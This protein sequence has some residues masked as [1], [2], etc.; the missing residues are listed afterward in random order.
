MTRNALPDPVPTSLCLLTRPSAI[1]GDAG[2]EV[3]LGLKKRGF[4]TGRIVG[5]GGHIEPGETPAQ[6]AARECHEETGI[7]VQVADLRRLGLV[8]FR[9]PARAAWD[10]SVAVFGAD[11]FSGEPAESDEIAPRWYPVA[12]LPLDRMWDD[13][14][15]WLPRMLAGERL[16]AE[17]SYAADCQTVDTVRISPSAS[18]RVEVVGDPD[19]DA[20]GGTPASPEE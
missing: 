3:L 1:P 19:P 15:H 16:Y 4:G 9:F 6:A 14:R 2:R 11:R 7:R 18:G 20:G 8:T 12:A 17:I 10:L 13:A 5:P